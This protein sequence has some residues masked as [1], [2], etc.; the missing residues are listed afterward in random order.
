[1]EEKRAVHLKTGEA[2]SLSKAEL[3]RIIKHAY[4][5]FNFVER[6]SAFPDK[7]EILKSRGF[8]NA[9]RHGGGSRQGD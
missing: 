1:M 4:G 9:V 3:T 2:A 8:V 6:W 5:S 7:R